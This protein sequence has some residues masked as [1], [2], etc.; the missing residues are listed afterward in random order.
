VARA[1]LSLQ[2]YG[3]ELEDLRVPVTW[4]L[5]E[6]YAGSISDEELVAMVA[7]MTPL[8]GLKSW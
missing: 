7:V 5:T 1:A 2:A 4:A 6:T 8:T 3:A